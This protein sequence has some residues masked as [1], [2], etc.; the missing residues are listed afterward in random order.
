MK[1]EFNHKKGFAFNGFLS[2]FFPPEKGISA[3]HYAEELKTDFP[4]IVYTEKT[5]GNCE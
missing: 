2:R 5:G 1:V 4:K 3:K